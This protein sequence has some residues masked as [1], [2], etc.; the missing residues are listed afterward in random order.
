MNHTAAGMTLV[1]V[2]CY[3]LNSVLVDR[4]LTKSHPLWIQLLTNGAI[5]VLCLVGIVCYKAWRADIPLQEPWSLTRMWFPVLL[6]NLC[7]FA[8]GLA[9][10]GAFRNGGSVTEVTAVLC[11]LPIVATLIGMAVDVYFFP[12]D[13]RKPLT[14]QEILGTAIIIMGIGIF[15]WKTPS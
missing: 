3:A 15:Y 6:C 10:Y 8:G 7:L 2:I 5:P 9:F 13:L 1:A 12:K 11:L 4:F 14:P